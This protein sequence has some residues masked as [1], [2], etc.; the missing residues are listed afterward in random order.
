M[1]KYSEKRVESVDGVTTREQLETGLDIL[2]LGE[3]QK[4]A[5]EYPHI[6]KVVLTYTFT[7]SVVVVTTE[8]ERT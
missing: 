1:N 5:F 2:D 3:V 6:T 7:N 8:K 4:L